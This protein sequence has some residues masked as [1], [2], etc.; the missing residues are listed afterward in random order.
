MAFGLNRVELIG[1]LGVDPV[2]RRS[3]GA[4]LLIVRQR[5]AAR[6]CTTDRHAERC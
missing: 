1:R 6:R 3:C 5:H 2:V 4:R